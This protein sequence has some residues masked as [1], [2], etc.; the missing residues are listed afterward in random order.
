MFPVFHFINCP[1]F[2]YIFIYYKQQRAI[3][4]LTCCTIQQCIH[5][6]PLRV[7]L[8]N[9]KILRL[10][11]CFKLNITAAP[12][13]TASPPGQV[14]L[15]LPRHAAATGINTAKTRGAFVRA[16][17]AGELQSR[18]LPVVHRLAQRLPGR[19]PATMVPAHLRVAMATDWL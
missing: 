2:I 3:R 18:L 8:R 16:I 6:T 17:R 5:D 7:L 19:R 13:C 10:L 11:A 1:T 9:N 15:P 14:P 4:P 12:A